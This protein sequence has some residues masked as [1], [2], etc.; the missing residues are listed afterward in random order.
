SGLVSLTA[1][2][3]PGLNVSLSLDNVMLSPGSSTTLVITIAVL[4]NAA[5]GSHA[6]SVGASHGSTTH[7][8]SVPVQA[9]APQQPYP[10]GEQPGQGLV[11]QISQVMKSSLWLLLLGILAG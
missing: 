6:A 3:D 11:S 10:P 9:T 5:T 4:T 7:L 1:Y 2:G 8:A